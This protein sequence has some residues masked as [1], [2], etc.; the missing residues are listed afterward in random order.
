MYMNWAVVGKRK[1]DKTRAIV[2]VL[3]GNKMI[4]VEVIV[5]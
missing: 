1:S 2:A 4:K 5:M 3:L